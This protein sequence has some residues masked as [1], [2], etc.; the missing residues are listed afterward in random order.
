MK[1]IPD[2]RSV[3]D[4]ELSNISREDIRTV[5]TKSLGAQDS[6]NQTSETLLNMIELT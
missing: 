2:M 1:D 5:S 3:E 6:C 4:D